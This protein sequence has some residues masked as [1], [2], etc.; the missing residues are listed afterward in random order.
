ML[1]INKYS[2]CS[3]IKAWQQFLQEQGCNPYGVDGAWGPHTEMATR[4]FQV[5]EGLPVDGLVGPLTYQAAKQLGFKI[6]PIHVPDGNI[7]VM[8]DLSHHNGEVDLQAAKNAGILAVF[9]KA[10]EGLEPK[11]N[12]PS[13]QRNRAEAKAAGLLWGA[14][15][16]GENGNGIL[17]GQHFLEIAQPDDQ[18]V[19]VLDYEWLRKDS[20]RNM[21]IKQAAD[22]AMTI[23]NNTGKYPGLYAG[24]GFKHDLSLASERD[25]ETL[26]LCWIW[27]AAYSCKVVVPPGWDEYTFWQYTS[28][29][30]VDGIGYCDRSFFQGNEA[31]LRNFWKERSCLV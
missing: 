18:T 28:H 5:K 17:Q 6:P 25:K 12:D 14:Y 16:F 11:Y 7:N 31:D 22:F 23:Y 3:T 9:N 10:T 15:H 2:P 20:S 30:E 27:P 21:T 24:W 19:L 4:R 1:I 29:A 13:Y 26:G 8:V